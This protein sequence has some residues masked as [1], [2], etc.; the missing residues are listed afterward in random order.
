MITMV[1]VGI[2]RPGYTPLIASEKAK[3]SAAFLS[4]SNIIFA[5]GV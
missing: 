1:D 3:F 4:V 2:E 5:Y